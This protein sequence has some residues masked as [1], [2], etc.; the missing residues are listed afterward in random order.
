MLVPTPSSSVTE[1]DGPLSSSELT[2]EL[3]AA[4]KAGAAL[5][6][7]QMEAEL[8]PK[9][10]AWKDAC[11]WIVAILTG[12]GSVASLLSFIAGVQAGLAAK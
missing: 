12:L 9:I 6:A 11:K 8:R 1:D 2:E 10:E 3:K 5:G 7:Q 4:E